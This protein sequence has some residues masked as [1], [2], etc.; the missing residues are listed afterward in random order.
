MYLGSHLGSETPGLCWLPGKTESSLS[1]AAQTMKKP[2]LGANEVSV[3]PVP[4]LPPV[5]LAARTPEAS[6]SHTGNLLTGLRA[7]AR[8]H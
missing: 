2:T 5:L 7:E 4:D 3:L 1:H 6:S 8:T